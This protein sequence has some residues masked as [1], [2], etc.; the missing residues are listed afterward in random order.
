VTPERVVLVLSGGGMKAMAHVGAVH[1]LEE[2]GLAPAELVGTS[3]GALIGALAAGGLS[4]DRLVPLVMGIRREDLVAPAR[5]DVFLKGLSA[6]SVLKP[7]PLRALLRRVLPVTDFSQ[8][9]RPLRVTAVDL[10]SGA[11][12]VF[13]AGG[14]SDCALADAVYASMALPP[15]F[16]PARIGGRRFVDGGVRAVLPLEL[17]AQAGADLVVAVDVGPVP[18]GPGAAVRQV[19]ALVEL[20]D[21]SLSIAM[22]DQKA[23]TI[24][25]WQ[26]T[27]G[28]PPLV[29]VTPAV[30]P[31]A[32]FA[33]DR[34]A[35]FIEAGYRATHAA[36]AARAAP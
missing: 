3:G 19:P 10:D 11:L 24:R 26:E 33:F 18:F 20:S 12:V 5:A 35:E 7:E 23:R 29:L 14:R 15:Y 32:T 8:L 2:C 16:P 34:T 13:G 25:S 28:R 31:H 36:L 17:G 27:K 9:L 4:Y 21:R 22:A 30:D 1:A 6:A